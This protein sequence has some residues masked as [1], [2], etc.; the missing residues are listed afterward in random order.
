M[1]SPRRQSKAR[2]TWVLG[3]RRSF[4]GGSLNNSYSSF[5]LSSGNYAPE[6]IQYCVIAGMSAFTCSL[7]TGRTSLM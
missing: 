7:T 6:H 4:I 2:V 1:Q 5:M 3:Q